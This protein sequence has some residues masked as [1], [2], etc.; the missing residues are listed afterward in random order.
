[1]ALS[2]LVM[3]ASPAGRHTLK[4][5]RG[6]GNKLNISPEKVSQDRQAS[7]LL[8]S[9]TQ[10]EISAIKIVSQLKILQPPLIYTARPRFLDG[11]KAATENSRDPRRQ[12]RK[13]KKRN[14]Y[15]FYL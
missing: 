7:A 12:A 6:L 9:T 4:L 1:M 13:E 15:V 3:T 10:A 11:M 2:H 14:Q 5:Q 8:L